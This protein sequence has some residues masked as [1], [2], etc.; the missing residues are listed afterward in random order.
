MSR[1]EDSLAKVNRKRRISE[2]HGSGVY[3]VLLEKSTP[4]K[5][6]KPR[7]IFI[8]IAILLGI[9]LYYLASNDFSKIPPKSV[10]VT[11]AGNTPPAVKQLA[12]KDSSEIH[13]KSVTVTNTGKTPPAVKKAAPVRLPEQENRIPSNIRS[14]SPDPGYSAAHPGWQRYE[15]DALEYR[16]FREG[17]R[18]KAIQ[19]IAKREKA[20]SAAFFD[21]FLKEIAKKE[22]FRVHS[23]ETRGGRFVEKGVAGKWTEVV[24]YR[25]KPAG[26]I[27]AFVVAYL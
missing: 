7:I 11:D 12:S 4:A 18:V 21:S 20:I 23:R 24:I 17:A 14:A 10:T 26:E 3:K 15:T 1:I 16:V 8:V 25:K 22:P 6:K 9:G 2:A 19:V 13:P 27:E 5:R